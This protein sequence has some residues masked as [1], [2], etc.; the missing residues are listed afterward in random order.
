MFAFLWNVALLFIF[1]YFVND[2]SATVGG[3]LESDFPQKISV[4]GIRIPVVEVV[5]AGAVAI[6]VRIIRLHDVLAKILGIRKNYMIKNILLPIAA[7]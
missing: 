3:W 1:S 5:I 2:I 7:Q 6:V 4:F